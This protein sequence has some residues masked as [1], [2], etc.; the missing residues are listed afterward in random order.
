VSRRRAARQQVKVRR[1]RLAL[2][3][4]TL[5]LL[6]GLALPVSALGGSAPDSAA[7]AL[8]GAADAGSGVVYVVQPGDTLGSIAARVDPGDPGH[9]AIVLARETGSATVV[10]GEHLTLP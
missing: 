8:A 7:T 10:P 1:H 5:G 3:V 2:G 6:A 4:L 9:M